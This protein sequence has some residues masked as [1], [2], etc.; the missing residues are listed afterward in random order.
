MPPQGPEEEDQ[1]LGQCILVNG[2]I[3][4]CIA[5]GLRPDHFAADSTRRTYDALL[6]LH[7]QSAEVSLVSV[8]RV[9]RDLGR[10]DQ[11]G[12]T[13]WLASLLTLPDISSRVEQHCRSVI[14]YWRARQLISLQQVSVANL[15]HPKGRPIQ[16]HLEEQESLL[17]GLTH[18][19]RKQSYEALGVVAGRMLRDYSQAIASG[20]NGVEITTGYEDIDKVTTGYHPGELIV[21]AAR[22]GMGKTALLCGQL[23]GI[24]RPPPEAK[25]GEAQELP[26]AVY[27]HSLEMP[28]EQIA[29]RLVC[30]LAAVEQPKLR[31]GTVSRAEWERMLQA[32]TELSRHPIYIDDRPAVTVEEL[33][34]NI[35]KIKR[36][37]ERGEIKA[38]AL[39]LA[40]IDY[41]QL[42]QGKQ[43]VPREQEVSSLSAGLKNTAKSEKIAVVA[44]SQLNR[45]VENRTGSAPDKAKRPALKDLRECIAAD[46]WVYDTRTGAR[47]R[48]RDLRAQVLVATLNPTWKIGRQ[49][50]TD[51]WST[52]VKPV[53]KLTTRT[54]RTLRATA[55]HPLRAL[56]GWKRLDELKVGESIAVPRVVP[57]PE[58][59]AGLFSAD[60]LRLLG[61]L[62]SDGTY[63]KHRSVSYVKNDPVL[64]ADVR[65]IAFSR[66]GITA[67]RHKCQGT[68]EQIELTVTGQGRRHNEL[69]AWLK[70]LGVHGQIGQDKRI[71]E[72]V[73]RESNGMLGI[74]LGALWAGDGSVVKRKGSAGWALKFTSTSR[75]LLEQ[76]LW[77]L[78]RLG[79]VGVLGK[80]EWNTKSTRPLATITIHDQEHIQRFL[81]MAPMPGIKGAKLQQAAM[82]SVPIELLNLAE[83]D[84]LWDA[85]VSV[86][87]DGESECFDVSVPGLAN[88]VCQNF[89]VHNSGAIEQDADMVAFIY[90]AAYYDRDAN[91]EAEFII[92]KQRNGPTCTVKLGFHGPT[93]TFRTLARGYEEFSN[94]GDAPPPPDYGYE[95]EERYP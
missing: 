53:L 50:V 92:E 33:R 43:G 44:L 15:Y 46:Q 3:D 35:R 83:S 69:I 2:D 79:I 59:P 37:I 85:V 41:L 36:E 11:V 32:A 28:R 90:R 77:V 1:I 80:P 23:L 42:M 89:I 25:E 71:P 4:R 38:K 95:E 14:D 70:R 73:L 31:L 65:R 13:P 39:V 34:S 24:T 19:Q 54:G 48:V 76:V 8:A 17:W 27:F 74:F 75:P 84:V 12:G 18:D 88:F 60:E 29:M 9:L 72:E 21:I 61:Y 58:D 55:N 49:P 63:L 47:T 16:E 62:I 68:S 20:K 67:K 56:S 86:E 82:A 6:T 22:P 52:G 7:A 78:T 81:E 93:T 5:E 57:E 45:G 51:V 26:S 94:F 91:D 40:A 30:S 10:L 87:P 66:F 64:V